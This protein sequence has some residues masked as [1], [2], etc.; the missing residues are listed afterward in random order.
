MPSDLFGSNITMAKTIMPSTGPIYVPNSET[1]AEDW[2][3]YTTN[4][5][6]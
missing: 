4:D 1:F 2:D 3:A 6:V 5:I